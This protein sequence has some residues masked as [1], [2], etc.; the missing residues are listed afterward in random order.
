MAHRGPV[1]GQNRHKIFPADQNMRPANLRE[2]LRFRVN[3]RC[4]LFPVKSNLCT[5]FPTELVLENHHHVGVLVSIIPRHT[6]SD[7]E[8][9]SL[10]GFCW[11]SYEY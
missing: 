11:R 5:R 7:A 3:L 9:R 6:C 2:E 4:C 10:G 8:Q 1:V